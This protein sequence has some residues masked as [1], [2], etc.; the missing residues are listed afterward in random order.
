MTKILN[1]C[2]RWFLIATSLVALLILQVDLYPQAA[3]CP[4]EA[5]DLP[6]P[7]LPSGTVNE[8]IPI[9]HILIIMQENHSFDN[10]FGRLNEFG[11]NGEVDG[12]SLDMVNMMYEG[13]PVNP[14]HLTSYCVPGLDQSWNGSHFSYNNGRND[15]FVHRSGDDAM[16][17]YEEEDLP[18]Y[19]SLANTFAIGDRYFSSVLGP[20]D[21]NGFYLFAGTSFGHI[22]NDGPLSRFNQPTLMDQL[23]DHGV[24]FIYYN[25][26]DP[27]IGKFAN[28]YSKDMD[29][30][31]GFEDF[32]EDAATGNLPQVAF[33]EPDPIFDE[34]PPHNVQLGQA[35]VASIV[36][37]LIK[38]PAWPRLA[39]FIT[40]D[41][42]DGYFDHV[43]PP[44]ACVPD[45]IQPMLG[46]DDVEA[47]F[48]RYG[49]RVPAIV[50]SPYAK[51]HYVSHEVYDH[52]SILRFVQTKY[53]LPALSNRDANANP[54]MDFFDFSYPNFDVPPLAEP[55][56]DGS[57]LEDCPELP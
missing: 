57:R 32:F 53:N 40:W 34:H 3:D 47:E 12:L 41:E 13:E 51:R 18:F 30:L 23:R 56:V 16:G 39:L 27:F 50:V 35:A 4:F 5:G 28:T 22:A 38:S 11:Y 46:Y 33:I 25:V 10:Y 49:F 7:D 8:E 6:D 29:K 21:P 17:Y 26:R 19:Y 31:K 37:A 45:D 36:N 43:P 24:S 2:S 42:H 48:D 55:I 52:T 15:M 1:D 14:F 9:D 44:P 20:S 54:M